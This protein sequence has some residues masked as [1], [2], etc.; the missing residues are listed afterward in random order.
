MQTLSTSNTPKGSPVENFT[1][2]ACVNLLAWLHVGDLVANRIDG[3]SCNHTDQKYAAIW[4]K[5]RKQPI[6]P[7]RIDDKTYTVNS[8]EESILLELLE[9]NEFLQ[10][11]LVNLS[12]A[13]DFSALD[14][15]GLSSHFQQAIDVMSSN[16]D[17]NGSLGTLWDALC[18][19]F[20]KL[21]AE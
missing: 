8:E 3:R 6:S 10:R 4:V 7:T 12:E 11:A 9:L 13:G 20:L 2:S 21:A 17:P 14:L 18:S 16:D 15:V 5:L 19:A 1:A